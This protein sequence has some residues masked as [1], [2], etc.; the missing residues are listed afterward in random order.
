MKDFTEKE[1]REQILHLVREYY[2]EFHQKDPND[3]AYIP[4]AGRVYDDQE[5]VNL[6]ESALDFW[7]TAGKWTEQFEKEFCK[8][9]QVRYCS[10]VNSGSSANLLAFMALTS[11]LLGGRAVQ[12]G[13]EVITVAAGF[14]TTITPI[15]QYGAV[16][17]FVDVTIP[18]YNLDP[19][20]L[21]QA[22]SPKTKAVMVAHSLGNPFDLKRV[23]SFVMTMGCGWWKTTAML[24]ARNTILMGP[25]GIPAP[26]G[27]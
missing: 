12:R 13:D 5:M 8:A 2:R 21:E 19:D 15:I 18:E 16:P 7:L 24:W 3:T 27:I 4:Y 10:V 23:R 25:G 26:S 22:L 9:L 20:Y 11:P 14:P 1:K 6:V 17:V